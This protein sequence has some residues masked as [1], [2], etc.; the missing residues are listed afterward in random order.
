MIKNA[1]RTKN[2]KDEIKYDFIG[3]LYEDKKKYNEK[4]KS[5]YCGR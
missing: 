5:H 2:K 3:G 4:I 1:Y